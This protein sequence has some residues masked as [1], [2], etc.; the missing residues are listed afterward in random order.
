MAYS[1]DPIFAAD[2]SNPANVA[3]NAAILI[4]DP[5][6]AGKAPVT[7]TDLTGSPLPNP[8]TVNKNGFG[9][10]F[11]HATLDRLAWS[12]AGFEGFFTSYEGMKNVAIAAQ[13]A[14]ETAASTAAAE[15]AVGVAPV[16]AE[17]EAAADAAAAAQAAAAQ[18]AAAAANSAALVGAPADTA[19]AAAANNT[20][21][22]FRAALSAT[23]GPDAVPMK[24]AFVQTGVD[25][26]DGY[27]NINRRL[28]LFDT[29]EANGTLLD[30]QHYG[31]TYPAYGIDIHNYKGADRA[32]VIH[33]Y[34]NLS[35]MIQ[36]DNTDNNT[37]IRMFNTANSVANP[38]G[39]GTGD[40][41]ELRDVNDG[42]VLKWNK[43]HLLTVTGKT[44]TILNSSVGKKVISLV[45]A[46][47]N[48]VIEANKGGTGGG[49]AVTVTNAGT[50]RG[51]FVAQNGAA[52]AL[53]L[54]MGTSAVGWHAFQISA[55]DY[56]AT[57]GTATDNGRTLE[58]NKN[59]T[60]AGEAVRI[61]NKGTGVSLTVRDAT[62]EL[63]ALTAAGLPK[64]SAA[65]N[66][67][68][69]VGA[70]GAAAALP[71]A[72]AKYLKVQDSAGTT[73]V[74]PAYAAV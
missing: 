32:L 57:I 8:V 72:P 63:F 6:D 11:Q 61:V 12:G 14:A 56:G 52:P 74:I 49:D 65:A 59:G 58:V 31:N 22:Q 25:P 10:A 26:A 62:A 44:F 33:Q 34:S 28:R 7:I 66:Q 2:P 30:I 67:Q 36:L 64:W 46:I 51:I 53:N 40:Y 71:A 42:S 15:A 69:T 68:T 16:V 45:T 43:D 54:T 39:L 60:G 50:G 23:Y 35:P 24:A 1:F 55:R 41:F 27:T 48:T 13:A 18:A 21:S 4:Y 3:A 47:D 38:G 17:A 29:P 9:S 5:N 19:M 37:F 20:G 70:A 73:Y